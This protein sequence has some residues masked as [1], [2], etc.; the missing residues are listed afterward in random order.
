MYLLHMPVALLLLDPMYDTRLK[1]WK[2]YLAYTV[3]V[4][5]VTALGSLLTWHLLE[6]RMLNLKKYFEY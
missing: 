6:K 3:A 1:G 2:M 5:A 4:Y